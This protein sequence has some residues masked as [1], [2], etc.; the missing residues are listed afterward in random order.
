MIIQPQNTTLSTAVPLFSRRPNSLDAPS[1]FN[2]H[3][4]KESFAKFDFDTYKADSTCREA[5]KE[6][7]SRYSIVQ[8]EDS[9]YALDDLLT[10]TSRRHAVDGTENASVSI[11]AVNE[12]RDTDEDKSILHSRKDVVEGQPQYQLPPVNVGS[13]TKL[14][15]LLAIVVGGAC[16]L[17][18]ILCSIGFWVNSHRPPL[19]LLPN[20]SPGE[21]LSFI[22]NIILTQ[23]LESL[24]YVHSISLRWALFKENRLVFNTNLRLLTSSRLSRPNSWY[25]NSISAML[26]VLCYACTSVLVM[27]EIKLA[28][29]DGLNQTLK[30]HVNLVALLVLG[31]SLSGQ[32]LLA[33]WC[34]YSNLRDIPSWGSNPLTSTIIMLNNRLAQHERGNCM[35]PV[36]IQNTSDGR[37]ILPRRRQPSQWQVSPSARLANI[38]IWILVGLSL[39]WFLIIV[40]IARSNMTNALSKL[41]PPTNSTWHFSLDWSSSANI[42]AT[43]FSTTAYYNA[44]LFSPDS[45]VQAGFEASMPFVSTLIVGIL[46]VCILQGLQTMGLHC[47]ELIVNLSRDEDSWRALNAYGRSSAKIHSILNPPLLA[48]LMSW[49]C[50]VLSIFKSLLHWLLGQATQPSFGSAGG[51]GFTVYFAMNYARLLVYGIC[52]TLFALVVTFLTVRKPKGPQP[53]TYGHIP[54]I[55][56]VIDDWTL[57][58]NG[59]FWWGDKG[60]GTDGGVRHAGMS[61]RREDLGPILMDALYAGEGIR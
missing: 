11:G 21:A 35:N 8:N 39:I 50:I 41:Y 19:I 13:G 29:G 45:S 20:D 26:L 4:T 44:V 55:A 31:F 40:F 49:K 18:C 15:C 37:P 10:S 46:F 5:S 30:P 58:K 9:A 2:H 56:N 1:L 25:M 28:V 12:H 52:A 23:C 16:S 43:E 24:A 59:C 3:H 34:Y 38:F 27:P 14:Q 7:D 60:Y 51:A 54:T 33:T 32:T 6:M 61:S 36:Q 42:N 48:A 47:G 53:A 57:D 22:A 17:L